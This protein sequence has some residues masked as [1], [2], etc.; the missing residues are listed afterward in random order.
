MDGVILLST[1][2]PYSLQEALRH[3]ISSQLLVLSS[4]LYFLITSCIFPA[5]ADEG[6]T[7]L[8]AVKPLK[9]KRKAYCGPRNLEK[10][11]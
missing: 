9:R 7:I 6:L 3:S 1:A 5:I 11:G 4:R 2:T 8:P 10:I